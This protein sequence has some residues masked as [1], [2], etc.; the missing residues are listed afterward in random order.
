MQLI[1][2]DFPERLTTLRHQRGLTQA[3][4][5]TIVD[6]HVS[7]IRRY[8]QGAAQPT[9]DV[10]RRLTLALNT[11]ADQLIFNT[12]PASNDWQLRIDAIQ[13]LDPD[14]Q[15]TIRTVIDGILIRHQARKLAS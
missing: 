13:H 1:T 11:S 6:I 5:A 15:A 10:I 9:L 2:M 8:E 4:L 12:D 3:A 7:Q 14:E